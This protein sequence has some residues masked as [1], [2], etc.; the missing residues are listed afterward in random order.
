MAASATPIPIRSHST[1]FFE[2]PLKRRKQRR[3][4]EQEQRQRALL[5]AEEESRSEAW[6]Y[7]IEFLQASEWC[8]QMGQITVVYDAVPTMDGLESYGF[9]DEKEGTIACRRLFKAPVVWDELGRGLWKLLRS[10]ADQ[11]RAAL[12]EVARANA[13]NS[14]ATEA[15][16]SLT[17]SRRS[18]S[19]RA[20]EDSCATTTSGESVSGHA[21]LSSSPPRKGSVP[22]IFSRITAR[23]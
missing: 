4:L 16:T 11:K 8:D 6:N 10:V 15:S 19:R 14:A 12:D 13:W 7:I 21:S 20:S 3:L 1:T 22:R 5:E 23:R 9:L 18:S 17:S 2:L